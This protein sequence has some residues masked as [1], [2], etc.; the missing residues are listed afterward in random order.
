VANG[1]NADSATTDAFLRRQNDADANLIVNS[2]SGNSLLFV[3]IDTIASER[4]GLESQIDLVIA[5]GSAGVRFVTIGTE[6]I[7]DMVV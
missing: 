1:R 4:P 2:S 6:L 3:M 7:D 5:C